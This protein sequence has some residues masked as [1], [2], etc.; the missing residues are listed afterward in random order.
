VH[1]A[2][3]VNPVKMVFPALPEL[4]VTLAAQVPLAHKVNPVLLDT[5]VVQDQLVQ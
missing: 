3:Q 5:L 1:L 2:N 4:L